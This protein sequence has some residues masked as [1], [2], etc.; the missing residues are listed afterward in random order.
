MVV[1]TPTEGPVKATQNSASRVRQDIAI[2]AKQLNDP[3]SG[4]GV[5]S[6]QKEGLSLPAL[7]HLRR[8]SGVLTGEAVLGEAD[9]TS[10]NYPQHSCDSRNNSSSHYPPISVIIIYARHHNPGRL[11]PEASPQRN[12]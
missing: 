1:Q 12:A 2:T 7:G 4:R 3:D 8:L 5:E 9:T 11:T 6:P 10:Q